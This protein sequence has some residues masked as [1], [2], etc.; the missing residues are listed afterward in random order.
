MQSRGLSKRTTPKKI[1][2]N[3]LVNFD[4]QKALLNKKIAMHN[5][6]TVDSSNTQESY[7]QTLTHTRT[8]SVSTCHNTT[9][10]SKH[11]AECKKN[12]EPLASAIEYLFKNQTKLGLIIGELANKFNELVTDMQKTKDQQYNDSVTCTTSRTAKSGNENQSEGNYLSNFNAL[13]TQIE[14]ISK[15][16]S[17]KFQQYEHFLKGT[18]N[19]NINIPSDELKPTNEQKQSTKMLLQSSMKKGSEFLSEYLQSPIENFAIKTQPTPIQSMNNLVTPESPGTILK[20]LDVKTEQKNNAEDEQGITASEDKERSFRKKPQLNFGALRLALGEANSAT[21]SRRSSQNKIEIPISPD[22][23]KKR[24][25]LHL[26]IPTRSPQTLAESVAEKTENYFA[27]TLRFMPSTSKTYRDTV[28]NAVKQKIIETNRNKRAELDS[29]ISRIHDETRVLKGSQTTREATFEKS[30]HIN[31]DEISVNLKNQ[32]AG[33]PLSPTDLGGSKTTAN[34]TLASGQKFEYSIQKIAIKPENNALQQK[35]LSE[36]SVRCSEEPSRLS[37]TS[38]QAK[39]MDQAA[40]LQTIARNEKMEIKSI[41]K[42]Q[43]GIESSHNR[44][45]F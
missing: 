35:E 13:L 22:A 21:S 20:E 16:T 38:Q 43:Y 41:M 7:N 39:A 2:R 8:P 5:A 10:A 34:A 27:K 9:G 14:L 29:V 28:S 3:R 1:D 19:K 37:S 15:E 24:P 36:T 11:P 25:V 18:E 45:I 6:I 26:N 44:G 31:L 42:E 40:A 12:F 33:N 23:R 4:A 17:K 30:R 32:T